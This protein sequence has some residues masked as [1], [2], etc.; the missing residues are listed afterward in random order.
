[1]DVKH[2]ATILLSRPMFHHTCICQTCFLFR[3]V[4]TFTF[5]CNPRLWLWIPMWKYETDDFYYNLPFPSPIPY[6]KQPLWSL[7]LAVFK[8]L[9]ISFPLM[10]LRFFVV[11]SQGG[12]ICVSLKTVFLAELSTRISA[13]SYKLHVQVAIKYTSY[14][15]TGFDCVATLC[16]Q[17]FVDN[18]LLPFNN[19]DLS[20]RRNLNLSHLANCV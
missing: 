7:I 17:K 20:K 16:T 18:I 1:M 15:E 11:D 19:T 14:Q 6:V 2:Y 3:C 5:I 12:I 10:E 13:W 4:P 8:L 9:D